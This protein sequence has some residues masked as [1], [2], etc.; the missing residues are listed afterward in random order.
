MQ[1]AFGRTPNQRI[2]IGNPNLWKPSKSCQFRTQQERNPCLAYE[3]ATFQ[4]TGPAPT[5]SIY[6]NLRV[7]ELLVSS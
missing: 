6:F 4:F 7:F 3:V 5:V 1:V 2:L